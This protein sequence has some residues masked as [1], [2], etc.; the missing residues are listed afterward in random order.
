[1]GMG[2]GL[3]SMGLLT[4]SEFGHFRVALMCVFLRDCSFDPY[5]HWILPCHLCTRQFRFWFSYQVDRFGDYMDPLY[6]QNFTKEEIAERKKFKYEAERPGNRFPYETVFGPG[7]LFAI[8]AD[9]FWRLG[10]YDE[11]Q[12]IV[13]CN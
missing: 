3:C 9:E 13:C 8:R 5:S 10:G 4:M 11:G 6:P 2:R 1:M 12:M 7:S